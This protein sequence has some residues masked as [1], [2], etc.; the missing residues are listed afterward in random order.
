MANSK[1]FV[2]KNGLETQNIQ[3]VEQ[4]GTET[5]TLTV[6]DDG[7]LSFSGSSGQLF[8]IV[9]SLTGSIFSVNDI[10]GIPSIEVFD[11]GKVILAESTGNVGIGVLTPTEKLTVSGNVSA[12]RLISTQ[13]TGTAP[14]TVA[15]T[16]VVTNLNADTVDG[17]DSSS[18]VQTTGDQSIAGTKTFT[19]NVNIAGVLDL[20]NTGVTGALDMSNNSIVGVNNI[21]ITDPGPNEGIS[22][23]GGNLWKIYESPNDLTTNGAG[24]LQIVQ[25]A[26]RR[27]TFN[28]SGQLEIPVATGTAPF[29]ITS[30]TAVTNLN[31]DTVDG[32]HAAGLSKR[33]NLTGQVQ[34]ASY[35]KS[36]IAL[37]ELTNTNPSANSYSIGMITFHRTNGLEAPA[38]MQIAMEKRYNVVG[39]NYTSLVQSGDS[40]GDN[41]QYIKFQYNGV[42]Y[43]GIE[44]FF[45]AAELSEVTF[46]G[47]S[48]FAIFGLDYFNTQTSTV[49]NSEINSSITVTDMVAE[50]DLFINNNKV[51]NAQN[52]GSGSGLDADLLDGLNS[53]YFLNTSVTG[54]T[55]T[56]LLTLGS[57]GTDYTGNNG[58]NH[59]LFLNGSTHSSIGFHDSADTIGHIRFSSASGFEIGR[60]D[61]TYGPHN[62]SLWGR[63][64]I[65]TSFS[66]TYRLNVSGNAFFDGGVAGHFFQDAS[67]GDYFVDPFG[68]ASG[69]SAILNGN[70]GIGTTTPAYRLDVA[71]GDIRV[72][73][74]GNV[75]GASGSINFNAN[76]NFLPMAQIKGSLGF[77]GSPSGVGQDQ[78]S[79]LFLIRNTTGNNEPLT[80]RMIIR[81]DGN[82]GIGTSSP[83]GTLQVR[84]DQT[85]DNAIIVSNAGTP[86]ANTTMSFVLQESD[87]PQGWFRR[88]RDGTAKTEIGFTNDLTFTSNI[89]SGATERMRITQAGNVGIGTSSP[90]TKLEVAGGQFRIFE[91]GNTAL[92]TYTAN[93]GG[94]IVSYQSDAGSPFTKTLDIVA[95]GD[96]TVPANMRFLAKANGASTPVE[97]MRIE[98][99]GNVGIGTTSPAE[100]LEVNGNIQ[101]QNTNGLKS[102]LAN[103][104]QKNLLS[105]NADDTIALGD[106]SSGY[107]A[108]RFFPGGSEAMRITSAGNVGIGTASPLAPL[109]VGTPDATQ[110]QR[111]IKV[112]NGTTTNTSGTYLDFPSATTD[113]L[114]SRIGGGREGLGGASFIR[115][116]T[117]NSSSVVTERMRILGNGNVGIGTS[118]PN[119]TLEVSTTNPINQRW[120]RGSPSSFY[121]D[122]KQ[123]ITSGN[124]RWNFSQVNNG[125]AYDDVLVLDTGKVGIGTT[126]PGAKLHINGATILSGAVSGGDTFLQIKNTTT[127]IALL[128]SEASMFGGATSSDVGLFVYGNNKLSLSTN[129]TRRLVID[130]AGNVGIG[131]T[132]PSEKLSVEGDAYIKDRLRVGLISTGNDS[133]Y[134]ENSVNSVDGAGGLYH[135][136]GDQTIA[137]FK[138]SPNEYIY[139][140]GNLKFV[141]STDTFEV[142]G[143]LTV[144]GNIVNTGST[145]TVNTT[146]LTVTDK[147]IELGVITPKTGLVATLSTGTANITLTTGTTEGMIPG[148]ALT[149]T[150]GTGV[151]GTNARIATI[152]GLT[153]LTAT[154]NHATAGSI[155]F[156][157]SG[158]T[159]FT[160][161]GGGI[162]LKGD[163]DHRIEWNKNYGAWTFSSDKLYLLS[164]TLDGDKLVIEDTDLE[165][166]ALVKISSVSTLPNDVGGALLR[167]NY[168]ATTSAVDAY[169]YGIDSSINPTSGVGSTSYAYAGRFN[170]S[171]AIANYGV[172]AQAQALNSGN[173][174]YALTANAIGVSGATVVAISASVSGAST[175]KYTFRGIGGTLYNDGSVGIGTDTPLNKLDIRITGADSND[176]IMVSR[177]DTTTTTNEILGGIGFD[178]TDGNVPSSVLEASAYIAAFA[179]EDH[180]TG[181]KGGYLTFG[182]APIDQDD[183]T[184]SSERMRITAGG[185][186]G[187]GTTSP[188]TTFHVN[189]E[190]LITNT[191]FF[192]PVGSGGNRLYI[193]NANLFGSTEMGLYENGGDAALAVYNPANTFMYYGNGQIVADAG[194][195][196]IGIGVGASAPSAKL[197]VVGDVKHTGLTMTSGTNVDQLKTTTFTS[198]LT[199]AWTDVTGVSGTYL[200]TGSYIVQIISN[201]EYYTGEMSWFSGTTTST[202]ADEIVLHRAGPAASAGRIFARVV[203]TSSAPSTL[204]LQVSGST[205]ISSHTM[206]FKFRRTI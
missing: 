160:A 167:L 31:A 147:N 61:G 98:G 118:A 19:G 39:A 51:W 2:V 99:N 116:D 14:F 185:N 45:S 206:T 150:S 52:D 13:T 90:A 89:V 15:S 49:I 3:F 165:E 134:L 44:F 157:A 159:D 148:Q 153:T 109:Q 32:F 170:S 75:G 199:T 81:Y 29:S 35:R 115:F 113:N 6:L 128:G 200:A 188:E 67:N 135:N 144:N 103:G 138:Q 171:G 71:G 21:E 5:I 194:A 106:G 191:A 92:K 12:T 104:T 123:T 70:V 110:Y 30:T 120:S 189:G 151:F 4:D 105:V 172:D 198:A 95:N 125:V 145:I 63:V 177:A 137:A 54:Q 88:Y 102:K 124:V 46:H 56:G 9:D 107:T 64:G 121:L 175:S 129:A 8:S 192:Q 72:Q 69:N 78:G 23:A 196:N 84:K 136:S 139:A 100:K 202:T 33:V 131:T 73:N 166:G 142:N 17:L 76:P 80:E 122:L 96:G 182:T 163:N 20:T 94:F 10:S 1:R 181:D 18:L 197:D 59:N 164:E 53:D 169:I 108:L 82:V 65:G 183:D 158:A 140:S 179:A 101:I 60:A 26:T 193:G 40:F 114:G 162:T 38:L 146:N 130:G 86:G 48:N 36:V 22:W 190:S 66:P 58:S 141:E 155:T 111:A 205:T 87:T 149:K 178:S 85:S 25:N 119:A 174:A 143:N 168:Q 41:V 161:D 34:T 203:R 42:W 27:A 28:T 97:R 204:K 126:T 93:P 77:A 173:S 43:G 47:E 83:L 112:G 91:S 133:I 37:C 127:N 50:N 154:I 156:T 117:T 176:G 132:T 187:I 152:T 55:K 68:N 186:V 184:V 11:D 24:N 79:L 7:S 180:S 201:G 74:G 16:T 195:G 62:T 57:T